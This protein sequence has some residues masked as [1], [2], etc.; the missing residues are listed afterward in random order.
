[1]IMCSLMGGSVGIPSQITSQSSWPLYRAVPGLTERVSVP[2]LAFMPLVARE[3]RAWLD[4]DPERVAVLH[5][6]GTVSSCNYLYQ[7]P[8]HLISWQGPIRNHGLQLSPHSR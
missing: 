5:C 2:P 1:M 8:T 6:K 3:M 4:G 7:A